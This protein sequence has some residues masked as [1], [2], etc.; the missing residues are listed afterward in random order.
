MLHA[1]DSFDTRYRDGWFFYWSYQ[2][3]D[4]GTP[5]TRHRKVIRSSDGQ[6]E[7]SIHFTFDLVHVDFCMF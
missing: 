4:K 2:P 3:K 7:G 6:S 1:C 5:R